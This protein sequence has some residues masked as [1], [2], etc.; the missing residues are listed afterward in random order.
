MSPEIKRI[1]GTLPDFRVGSFATQLAKRIKDEGGAIAEG[2]AM[3][4]CEQDKQMQ[5]LT[6]QNTKLKETSDNQNILADNQEKLYESQEELKATV[7]EIKEE[8]KL[9]DN[10]FNA[11]K[12]VGVWIITA[13]GGISGWLLVKL[14]GP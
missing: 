4:I 2:V 3:L 1:T 14:F 12:N 11:Y 9:K 13:V 8:R 5:H 7:E 10:S 6:W